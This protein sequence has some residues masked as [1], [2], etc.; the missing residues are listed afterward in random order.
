LGAFG[1]DMHQISIKLDGK[2][3]FGHTSDGY[4]IVRCI[5]DVQR[6]LES[7]GVC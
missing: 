5:G 1:V 6:V 4:Q 2:T 3:S 7:D